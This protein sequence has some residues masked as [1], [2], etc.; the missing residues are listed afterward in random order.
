M[1]SFPDSHKDLLEAPVASLTTIGANGYPQSTLTWFAY[2]DGQIKL[3]LSRSRQKTKNL[4]K[5]PK[6]SLLILDP[7][8][9]MRYLEIRGDATAAADPDL[10]FAKG[11][12][13]T[14]YNADVTSYDQP[15]DERLVI[16]IA[17]TNVYAVDMRG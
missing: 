12:I 13:G 1:T 4:F 10:K 7:G 17:P 11:T 8:S 14:K 2:E 16:T 9:P 15:G 5:N 6:V 3:S